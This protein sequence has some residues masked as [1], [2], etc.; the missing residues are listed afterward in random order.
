[1]KMK[2]RVIIIAAW[3]FIIAVQLFEMT[4]EGATPS[5]VITIVAASIVIL[6]EVIRWRE[7]AK[8]H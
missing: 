4:K 5:R 2:W 8:N 1:M 7:G 3:L 6:V